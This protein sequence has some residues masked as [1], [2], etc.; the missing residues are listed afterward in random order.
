M[1][2]FQTA[3]LIG[4][5]FVAILN[6]NEKRALLWIAVGALNFTLTALYQDHAL[7]W[8]PHPFVT[9]VADATTVILL[10][11]CGIYKWER[12]V[13]YAFMVSILVS[14]A[15]LLGWIPDRTSYVI[16]LE[17]CNWLALLVM[18]GSGIARLADER[19]NSGVVVQGARTGVGRM[20]HRVRAT[21]DATRQPKGVLA[22]ALG[23]GQKVG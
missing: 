5:V 19:A 15:F 6:Y 2:I 14:I 16:G 22:R 21:F 7:L 9:G 20:L 4:A 23:Q 13:R 10:A 17:G 1:D 8:L 11:T 3:L 12:F 18:G